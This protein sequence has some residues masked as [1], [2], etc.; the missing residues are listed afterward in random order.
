[1]LMPEEIN[2]KRNR[3]ADDGTLS[4]ILFYVIV[5]QLQRPAGL[6]LVYADNCYNRI[7]HPM[8]SMVFQSFGVPT[9]AT[10]SILTMIQNM[11][12]Y[13]RTG[14]GDSNGCD[15]WVGNSSRNVRKT[16]GICQGNGAALA[17]WTFMSI[18]MIATQCKKVFCAHLIAPISSQ[19][20]HL[21]GS[22][23]LMMPI[24]SIWRCA[25]MKMCSKRTQNSKMALSTGENYSFQLLVL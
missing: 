4:K 8:A 2:S 11:E 17:A 25:D 19:Q 23:L 24:F 1:M 16:Q 9:S 20:G 3:L 18:P 22:Y 13:L 7:A 14:Y 10:E 21:S 12:F 6:G 5:R 15:G